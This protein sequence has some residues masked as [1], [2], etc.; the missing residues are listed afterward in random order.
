[1]QPLNAPVNDALPHEC[2]LILPLLRIPVVLL[3]IVGDADPLIP[4]GLLESCA[5]PPL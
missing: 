5:Q 1:M 2:L 4:H 3:V